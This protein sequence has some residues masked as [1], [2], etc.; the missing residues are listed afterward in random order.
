VLGGAELRYNVTRALQLASFLDLGNVFLQIRDVDLGELRRSTGLGL[1]YRTPI[2]PV[3]LDW[4]YVLDHRPGEPRSH[5][6][7]TIGHAF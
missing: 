2:G 1:R 5:W 7:L 3:R 4:G 6:H